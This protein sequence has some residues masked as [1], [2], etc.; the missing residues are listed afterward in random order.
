VTDNY[1]RIINPENWAVEWTSPLLNLTASNYQIAIDNID[2]DPA[3]EIILG[4]NRIHVL[5]PGNGDHTQTD[6]DNYSSFDIYDLDGNGIR[7][8]VAGTE[9]GRILRWN[10]GGQT[11]E[12]LPVDMGSRINSLKV[13]DIHGNE[14]PELVF[15]TGG[16]VWFSTLSGN[17]VFTDRLGSGLNPY[18]RILITDFDGNGEKEVFAATSDQVTE[19]GPHCYECVNFDIR[20]AG[21]DL[22]CVPDNDGWITMDAWGGIQPYDYFW[23]NDS[24]WNSG[25]NDSTQVSLQNLVPGTYTVTALDHVGCVE[26]ETIVLEPPRV[27]AVISTTVAGCDDAHPGAV[28]LSDIAGLPPY[29]F[30][31]NYAGNGPLIS[32][33]PPGLY[34]VTITDSRECTGEY[35]AEVKQDSVKISHSILNP[36]C[37]EDFGQFIAT[38]TG[39]G[40]FNFSWSDAAGTELLNFSWPDGLNSP[41]PVYLKQGNYILTVKDQVGCSDSV[42]DSIVAPPP[43]EVRSLVMSDSPSSAGY[44]GSIV[45]APSGGTPP[46]KVL[47]LHDITLREFEARE[48][49]QGTYKVVVSDSLGCKQ[50]LALKVEYAP[51][52]HLC[53][54]YPVP[55]DDMLTIDFGGSL[56]NG[57][58]VSAILYDTRG[59]AVF[60]SP[61][62]NDVNRLML[63]YLREGLYLLRIIVDL[64]EEVF[65]VERFYGD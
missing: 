27:K 38:A 2:T 17:M 18:D 41:E 16:R 55:F 8:I 15:M 64:K 1:V 51:R 42:M 35:S 4:G 36:D 43:L 37:F 31:W 48:L 56:N 60:D 11:M 23:S 59:R 52:E 29:R 65:K 3:K 40:S 20:V 54:V 53:R 25:G 5:D 30:E 63:G 7:D 14:E 13:A 19:L 33:V 21:E 34:S 61:L 44:D 9:D 26:R 32:P 6:K 22:T 47:W 49:G 46:Y 57:A 39:T 24:T 12:A 28:S 62:H 45:L 10:I 50:S 58:L